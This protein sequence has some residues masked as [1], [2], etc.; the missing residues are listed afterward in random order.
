MLILRFLL[1]VSIL[2]SLVT[3]FFNAKGVV[4]LF[5]S[6]MQAMAALGFASLLFAQTFGVGVIE[7]YARG[8]P[9]A[10]KVLTPWPSA[11]HH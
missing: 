11:R 3:L 2:G 1:V 4:Y 5:P 10:P 8:L 7:A 6:V 9:G